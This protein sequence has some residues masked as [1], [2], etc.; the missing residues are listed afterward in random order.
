MVQH[1]ARKSAL[2][3]RI[4]LL[5]A[6]FDQARR[7]VIYVNDN[8]TGW[9]GGF[10]DL[11]AACRQ[12]GGDSRTLAER[13]APCDDHYCIL[14]PTHS[15]F[16]QSALPTLLA[17]LRVDA[18]GLAGRAAASCVLAT[19]LDAHMRDLA[20]WVTAEQFGR[21][22]R[23]WRARLYRTP[24]GYRLMATHRRHAPDE[25][26]VADAFEALGVDTVYGEPCRQ[27]QCF[28]ARFTA[29]PWRI[30]IH[31]KLK[32]AYAVWQPEHAQLPQRQAWIAEYERKASEHAACHYP[33]TLGKGR[34]DADILPVVELHDRLCHAQQK[35]LPLACSMTHGRGQR[36]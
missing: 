15:A 14:K 13:L 36:A 7:P 1:W 32:P 29:K 21:S 10:A 8:C 22:Q 19:A 30:G 31:D 11:V 33:E 17:Q 23:D 2:C 27:Q 25:P 6:R 16:R 5:R 4:L 26:A 20:P 18:L 3:R 35:R 34:D 24:N 9:Q 28:R 12:A